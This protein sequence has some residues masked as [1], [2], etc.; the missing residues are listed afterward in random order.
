MI[1]QGEYAH[2]EY[3]TDTAWLAEHLEDEDLCVVD[4][5]VLD[6]Y[7]RAHIPGSVLIPDNF[8]K[9]PDTDRTDILP[10]VKFAAVME[11][12]GIGDNTKVITYDNSGGVYAGR[13]WWA[14]RYYGHRNVSCLNGGWRKWITE[15]YRVG[16]RRPRIHKGAIFT[17]VLDPSV[18]IS[19]DQLKHEYDQAAVVVWDVRSVG[20]HT[21]GETRG[22]RRPGHIPGSVHMEWVELIDQETHELKPASVMRKILE[23]NGIIS[24]KRIVPH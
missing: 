23:S 24:D 1:N 21:G 15:G 13:L 19:T 20:E 8:Q 3:L 2:P 17:P 10:P 6:Q 7:R 5:D 18:F 14:L 9:D 22:N 11:S 16:L 12:L 4:T